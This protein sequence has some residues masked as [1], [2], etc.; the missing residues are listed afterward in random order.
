MPRRAGVVLATIVA[1]VWFVLGVA[2]FGSLALDAVGMS[3]D[4]CTVSLLGQQGEVSWQWWPPGT[5]CTS[6]SGIEYREPS[7]LRG[8][9]VLV[10]LVLG[11]LLIVAWRVLRNAPEP[12]WQE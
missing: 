4:E 10:E 11:V 6:P 1:I 3:D 2:L 12:D 9:L 8:W 7:A 5:T